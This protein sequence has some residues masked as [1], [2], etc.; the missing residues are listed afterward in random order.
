MPAGSCHSRSDN[1][2]GLGCLLLE[3]AEFNNDTI[4]TVGL[5][6]LA[7]VAAMQNQPAIRTFLPFMEHPPQ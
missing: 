2:P 1:Q 5:A 4:G 7:D 3:P 6:R